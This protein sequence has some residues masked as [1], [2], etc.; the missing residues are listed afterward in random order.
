MIYSHYSP[1]PF[2]ALMGTLPGA[3]SRAQSAFPQYKSQVLLRFI[4]LKIE[5]INT[6]IS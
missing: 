4:E 2:G 3:Q 6:V 1:R 5:E